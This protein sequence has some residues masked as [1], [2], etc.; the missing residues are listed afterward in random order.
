MPF[1]VFGSGA[2]ASQ[3]FFGKIREYTLFTSLALV[4]GYLAL[5]LQLI[6]IG[7]AAMFYLSAF[8]LGLALVFNQIVSEVPDEVQL[9]TY[10]LGQIMPLLTGTQLFCTILDVFVPLTGRMGVEAPGEHIIA[11]IVA[12]SGAYTLPLV[13]PFAHRFSRRWLFRSVLLLSIA[14]GVSMLVFIR[15]SPFDEMH[16][17]RLFVIHMENVSL[18]PLYGA[19]STDSVG[20]R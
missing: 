15:R 19:S 13:I 3:L 20:Y 18:I 4:Q 14:S 2:L 8:P 10:A 12:I 6:G 17:K 9:W 5:T 11:S 16:Q 1:E 7:S